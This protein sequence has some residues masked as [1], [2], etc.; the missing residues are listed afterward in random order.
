MAFVKNLFIGIICIVIFA[1]GYYF[2]TQNGSDFNL[3][4]SIVVSDDLI[5]RTAIFIERR[6]ILESLN[7]DT[8]IYSDPRFNTLRSYT[9]TVP[10]Q[11]IGRENIFA[12]PV[13]V[14]EARTA[15]LQ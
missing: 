6:A 8:K 5:S 10:E 11:P 4:G 14:P 9:T 7:L 1:F 2:L 15:T 3:D 13:A 12:V